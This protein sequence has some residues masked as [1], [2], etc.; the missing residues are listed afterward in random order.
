MSGSVQVTTR[1]MDFEKLFNDGLR[2]YF[3]RVMLAGHRAASASAPVD[4]GILRGSMA[5]GGG[6]TRVDTANP[7]QWAIVESPLK[8]P[9]DKKGRPYG[10]ILEESEHAHYLRGPHQGKNTKGWLSNIRGTIAPDIKMYLDAFKGEL[11]DGWKH[12]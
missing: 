12:G 5:P 8:T 10:R 6:A 7:P 9:A 4:K 1:T 2:R 3:T 11:K